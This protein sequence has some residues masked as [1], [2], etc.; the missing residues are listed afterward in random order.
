[1]HRA[2]RAPGAT[3]DDAAGP[4]RVTLCP[5]D[6]VTGTTPTAGRRYRVAW[7]T[8]ASGADPADVFARRYAGRAGA[9]WLDSGA[10]DGGRYSVVGA[11]D[12]VV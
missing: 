10:A 8:V 4:G 1:M 5:V 3:G 7:S 6:S 11:A 9:F 2:I 12:G